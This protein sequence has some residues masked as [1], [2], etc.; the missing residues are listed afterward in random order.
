MVYNLI[1]VPLPQ[2]CYVVTESFQ[3]ILEKYRARM[4]LLAATLERDGR[5]HAVSQRDPTYSMLL[6]R[7]GSSEATW[8]VTSFRGREPVGHREHDILQGGSPIQNALGAF[9]GDD[10]LRPR[11]AGRRAGSVVTPAP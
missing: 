6:T 1:H 3:T 10:M 8:R 11:A 5:L 4:R 7:N 2:P 9:V